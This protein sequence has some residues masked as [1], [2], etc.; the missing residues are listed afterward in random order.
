MRHLPTTVYGVIRDA[1]GKC[2]AMYYR[3]VTVVVVVLGFRCLVG[4]YCRLSLRR[5]EGTHA[6]LC[7]E[8]SNLES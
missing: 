3:R 8:G 5:G 2:R 1:G 4:R 6:S 7:E